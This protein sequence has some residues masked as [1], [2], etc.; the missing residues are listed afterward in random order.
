MR[1]AMMSAEGAVAAVDSSPEAS[2]AADVRAGLE[3]VPKRLPPY[4]FYDTEGSRLYEKITLLPE[5]YLTRTESAILREHAD[6]IVGRASRGPGPLRIIELGAG[7]A[8]KTELLL[9]AAQ[10]RQ[11]TCVY[12][13]VDVSRSA[14]EEAK[15]RLARELPEVDVQPH[16]M[17]HFEAFR[18]LRRAQGPDLVLFIGSSIG[19]FDDDEAVALLAGVHDA[20]G[21][22]ASLLLGTDLR[23]SPDVL[24]RAYDDPSG[25]TAA[26]NKNL[27]VRINRELAGDFDT[28]RFRHVARWNEGASRIEMHL[29]SVM[30]QTVNIEALGMRVAFE[31]KETIHTESS[32]KYDLP[33]VTRLLADAGF[34]LEETFYDA[35]RRFAVHLAGEAR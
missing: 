15:E 20:L 7:S 25:V 17:P 1:E 35:D 23:K 11:D 3:A 33:R 30:R 13:P 27:L 9:R 32:V 18:H 34:H 2:I 31:P 14:I 21:H 8:T 29:E 22:R 4:L 24:L 26:F 6:E 19:N 12:V 5:Y 28:S 10:R 16:V